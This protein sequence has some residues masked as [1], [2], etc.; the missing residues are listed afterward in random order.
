MIKN[1]ELLE[2]YNKVWDKVGNIIKKGFDSEP[3]Y[4]EKHVKNKIK[5]YQEKVNTYIH[6][7]KILEGGSHCI[8]LSVT[9]IDSVFKMG[10]TIIF[11]CF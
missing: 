3:V 5:F 6:N 10:K 9:L 11:E 4:N 1:D 8:C 2:K 7:D